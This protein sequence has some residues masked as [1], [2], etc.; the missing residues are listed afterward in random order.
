MNT[1]ITPCPD[2]SIIDHP[3][4]EHPDYLISAKT[5]FA[6][7]ISEIPMLY[8]LFPYAVSMVVGT[9][10]VGKSMILRQLGMCAANKSNFL[11]R[12]YNGQGR[13][14]IICCTEDDETAIAFLLR[15]Q[16]QSLHLSQEAKGR[17]S[18]IFDT[19]DIVAKIEEQL[20]NEP[21]ELV[22]LDALGDLAKCDSNSNSA[23]RD[24][25]S[26]FSI[27]ANQYRCP[28]VFLH[29]TGKRTQRLMPSKDNAIGAQGIEGKSR[30]VAELR[31]SQDNPNTRHF[32]IVKGNYLENSMKTSSFDLNMDDNFCFFDSGRRTPY[33]ELAEPQEPQKQTQPAKIDDVVHQAFLD[34]L[35]FD[36][37]GKPLSGRALTE[38]IMTHFQIGDRTARGFVDYYQQKNWVKNISE[39]KNKQYAR[40]L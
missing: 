30:F 7:N 40:G 14:V 2:F 4:Q 36:A 19:R 11:G 24:F 13:R 27:L 39:T 18:F 23:M 25:L 26:D 3:E 38:K 31:Q 1:I 37:D 28:F 15:R 5:L 34:S 17:L 6:L 22:I 8:G 32:C 33:A 21:A 35:F 12:P 16:D 10:D 20:A 29:H 9:S